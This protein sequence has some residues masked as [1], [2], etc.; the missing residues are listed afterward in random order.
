M[1]NTREDRGKIQNFFIIYCQSPCATIRRCDCIRLRILLQR[2]PVFAVATLSST[3]MFILMHASP[4][5]TRIKI[6]RLYL[7]DYIL[8]SR[9]SDGILQLDS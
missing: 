1:G 8:F 2:K 9:I 6:Q 4:F 7:F 5:L 3:Y